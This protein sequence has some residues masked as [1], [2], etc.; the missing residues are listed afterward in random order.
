[1]NTL[2]VGINGAGRIGRLVIRI[3]ADHPD[4]EIAC[5]NDLMDIE[6]LKYLLTYDSVH[7]KFKYPI[8][9]EDNSLII[10]GNKVPYVQIKEP[11][12]IPWSSFEVD[13]VIE[14]SGLFTTREV[15]QKHL[16]S[17]AKRVILS[18]PTKDESIKTIVM[19]INDCILS[20]DDDI[21][22][23]A[24]CTANGAAPILHVMQ[25]NFGI[26]VAFMTTVH[27]FTNN[28]RIMDAPHSDPRRSRSLANNIIPTHST[29]VDAIHQIFPFLKDKFQGVAIRVPIPAGALLELMIKTEKP[30]SIEK[31]N[32]A[33]IEASLGNLKNILEFTE[34]E[35]VSSDIVNNTSSCVFDSKMTKIINDHYCYLAAWYDNE[36][37]YAN[38]VVDLALKL[39][40]LN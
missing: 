10:A 29:A 7:Q 40:S 22:S 1:M 38:R 8:E 32:N 5:I 30:I 15:L 4:I 11:G 3:L 13:T 12:N 24:S 27:P 9:I 36:T 26:E 6:T 31:I 16:D 39:G 23:N 34:D 37:G 33:F 14:S 25:Q 2:R 18:C 35:L 19:G 17:G 21:V 20:S 28:Q